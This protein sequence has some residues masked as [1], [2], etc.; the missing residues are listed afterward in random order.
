MFKGPLHIVRS[1]LVFLEDGPDDDDDDADDEDD[2]ATTS[3]FLLT[4][5]LSSSAPQSRSPEEPKP[6]WAEA[7]CTK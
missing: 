3:D 1:R 7:R 5:A 4:V 6:N 2:D